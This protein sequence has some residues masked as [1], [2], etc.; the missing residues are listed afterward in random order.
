MSRS[1]KKH[2]GFKDHHKSKKYW[3]RQAAKRVRS[4]QRALDNGAAYKNLFNRWDICDW[5]F[6][7][8]SKQAVIDW[9]RGWREDPWKYWMK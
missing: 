6:R 3:K 2:P 1:F 7:F 9:V 8:Y 4:Y 5:N